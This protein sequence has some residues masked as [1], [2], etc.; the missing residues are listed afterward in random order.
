M[1]KSRS[2]F[3]GIVFTDETTINYYDS[4]GKKFVYEESNDKPFKVRH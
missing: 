3:K 4:D 1:K 2:G